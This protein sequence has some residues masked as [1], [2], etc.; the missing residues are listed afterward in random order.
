MNPDG[1]AESLLPDTAT[2]AREIRGWLLGRISKGGTAGAIAP[3]AADLN[4]VPRVLDWWVLEG[5]SY[6]GLE[7]PL[8]WSWPEVAAEIRRLSSAWGAEWK[9]SESPAGEVDWPATAQARLGALRP[10]YVQRASTP[11]LTPEEAAALAGW[12]TWVARRWAGYVAAVGP[13]GLV[14]QDLPIE[15]GEP[16]DAEPL[17]DERRLQ[18]WAHTARRSRWPLLR[19]VVAESLRATFEPEELDALP[20][21]PK[22]E[23]LFELVCATRIMRAVGGAGGV[24]RWLGTGTGEGGNRIGVP[25]VRGLYQH[26]VGA[27]VREAARHL[28]PL[29]EALERHR[30]VKGLPR[31]IDLLFE[32]DPPRRGFAGILL[33]AKSGGQDFADTVWQLGVYRAALRT[34]DPRPLLVW[35]VV[36]RTSTPVDL[37]QALAGVTDRLQ[38]G[39]ADEDL[40]LFTTGDQIPEALALLGLVDGG[41]APVS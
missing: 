37:T 5:K 30:V 3:V 41:P 17:P 2:Y 9:L 22:R 14:P 11:G 24:V 19:N 7:R 26:D 18:R 25:G 15:I 29:S 27:E 38:R 39:S 10:V 16:G 4:A 12:R 36:E 35:G 21:P 6:H 34:K 31:E 32:L 28:G 1:A 33:E 23:D 13:P 40:W 8:A 20:L